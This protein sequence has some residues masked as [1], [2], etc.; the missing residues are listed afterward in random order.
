MRRFLVAYAG[1]RMELTPARR[2]QLADQVGPGLAKLLPIEVSAFGTAAVLDGLAA[3]IY[4][5][6]QA[7]AR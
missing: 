2:Q 7:Q 4:A 5:D 3:L 1:R 6:Q